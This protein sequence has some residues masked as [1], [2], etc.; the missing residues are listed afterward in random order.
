MLYVGLN[1]VVKYFIKYDTQITERYNYA[2]YM[3]ILGSDSTL[4][5]DLHLR[6]IYLF[7]Y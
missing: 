1:L 3:L 4:E 7:I 2:G 6:P 5:E